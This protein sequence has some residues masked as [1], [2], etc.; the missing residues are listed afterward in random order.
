MNTMHDYGGMD[1]FTL[2]ERD[3]G[4][5]LKEDWEKQVWG[6]AITVWAKG[7][8]GYRGSS[9]ADIER[10]PPELYI[11]MPYYA[12]WLWAEEESII[13]SGLTNEEELNNPDG[14]VKMPEGPAF[15]P[16]TPADVIAFLEGDDSSE[17]PATVEPGFVVGDEVVVRNEHPTGHTRVPRYLRGH[18]G[19]IQK[20]H[21][22]HHFQ[23]DVPEGEDPG[24]QHLY[25]VAFTGPELW[26]RRANV[27]DKIHAEIW[28]YHLEPAS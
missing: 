4:P 26:G 12:K 11:D 28:E 27:K 5:I 10:I 21:G 17:I 22:V 3:Q 13:Q 7:M 14:N 25:T 24:Q 23:D 9:R 8:H 20:H 19:I 1:G 15:V 18:R 16:A 6:L 2:P